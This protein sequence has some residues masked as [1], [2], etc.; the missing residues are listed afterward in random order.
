MIDVRLRP[1]SSA[2]GARPAS[3]DEKRRGEGANCAEAHSPMCR[4]AQCRAGFAG[5]RALRPAP[6]RNKFTWWRIY[7]FVRG[8][9]SPHPRPVLSRG[10]TTP[11]VAPR[12]FREYR[13]VRPMRT[14]A[15]WADL[16][17]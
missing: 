5:G 9:A 6:L 8:T 16:I 12:D 2:P 15:R 7:T 14:V 1:A 3:N 13:S 10:G 11:A 4:G 17:M